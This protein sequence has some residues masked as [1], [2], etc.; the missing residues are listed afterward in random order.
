MLTL[1]RSTRPAGWVLLLNAACTA[2]AAQPLAY[3]V[4]TRYA[5]DGSVWAQTIGVEITPAGDSLKVTFRDA[6]L[7][8]ERAPAEQEAAIEAAFG[9]NRPG[10]SYCI[11]NFTI[12]RP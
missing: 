8:F 5:S 11:D 2:F 10:A 9:G 7:A 12:R 4:T 3:D 1:L 6:K